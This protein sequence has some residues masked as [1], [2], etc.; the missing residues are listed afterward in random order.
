MVSPQNKIPTESNKEF[1]KDGWVGPGEEVHIRF[2]NILKD[3]KLF[4]FCFNDE[5]Y[6]RYKK[7]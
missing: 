1:W 7:A 4:C 5:L 6:Q 3:R 2:S